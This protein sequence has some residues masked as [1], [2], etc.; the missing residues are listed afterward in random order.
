MS[1]SSLFFLLGILSFLCVCAFRLNKEEWRRN[2]ERKKGRKKKQD[3]FDLAS[4][5]WPTELEATKWAIG[6]TWKT[7]GRP[8]APLKVRAVRKHQVGVLG[9]IGDGRRHT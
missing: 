7:F 9:R 2:R 6:T 8:L 4:R 3:R 5:C 1:H